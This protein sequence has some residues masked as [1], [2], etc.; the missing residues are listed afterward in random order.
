MSKHVGER[1][2]TG[3]PEDI[4]PVPRVFWAR[5]VLQAH[6]NPEL[7]GTPAYE[8]LLSEA[9][10]VTPELC[11][12]FPGVYEGVETIVAEREML[13]KTAIVCRDD[14]AGLQ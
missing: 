1:Q 5:L 14:M 10:K 6:K 13:A 12:D 2:Q 4:T 8:N 3:Y 9:A 11:R 7:H